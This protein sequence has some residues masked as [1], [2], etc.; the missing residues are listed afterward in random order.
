MRS[1]L[2]LFIAAI[3][4]VVLAA[5][6][7]QTELRS[8]EKG[9]EFEWVRPMT[10]LDSALFARSWDYSIRNDPKPILRSIEGTLDS[11][12]NAAINLY[13][14]NSLAVFQMKVDASGHASSLECPMKDCD[15]AIVEKMEYLLPRMRFWPALAD[16]N[17]VAS[18]HV[19]VLNQRGADFIPPQVRGP[20]PD[21]EA[22]L[23]LKNYQTRKGECIQGVSWIRL[24]I[25]PNGKIKEELIAKS[26]DPFITDNVLPA[27]R[28]LKFSPGKKNG[29]AT[30]IWYTIR[31]A[32][33]S[34]YC[35][36]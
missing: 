2:F 11:T 4:P 5:Q 6:E 31:V 21:F 1:I 10:F 9:V 20:L 8:V 23:K 17:P 7:V 12:I 22:I 25:D 3:T 24:L 32:Y 14:V 28:A 35:K 36:D 27:I 18:T 13:N 33:R 26:D 34:S 19:H 16:G 29:V 30:D 15:P